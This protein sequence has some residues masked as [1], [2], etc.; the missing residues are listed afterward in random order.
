M[1][2]VDN[3]GQWVSVDSRPVVGEKGTL[4]RI[5]SSFKS[6][7]KASTKGDSAPN[8]LLCL[9]IRCPTATYDVNVEPAKDDVLFTDEEILTKLCE[10]VFGA[11][12]HRSEPEN[13]QYC[14]DST[15]EFSNKLFTEVALRSESRSE[16]EQTPT[17]LISSSPFD[18]APCSL[19]QAHLSNPIAGARGMLPPAEAEGQY[20]SAADESQAGE[21]P[22]ECPPTHNGRGESPSAGTGYSEEIVDP[23]LPSPVPLNPWTIARMT[24]TSR[25]GQQPHRS[26]GELV[27]RSSPPHPTTQ[28]E[29]RVS[30]PN[31]VTMSSP[32]RGPSQRLDQRISHLPASIATSP[33]RKQGSGSRRQQL[34][35]PKQSMDNWVHRTSRST[36]MDAGA[37]IEPRTPPQ[38]IVSASQA[39]RRPARG[40]AL[41]SSHQPFKMPLTRQAASDA[42]LD[43]SAPFSL[44]D[45]RLEAVASDDGVRMG[46]EV[47]PNVA[48]ADVDHAHCSDLE[49][50]PRVSI[51][52]LVLQCNVDLSQIERMQESTRSQDSLVFEGETDGFA[53]PDCKL[54]ESS[55]KPMPIAGLLTGPLDLQ[56]ALRDHLAVFG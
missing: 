37:N 2:L 19:R 28:R 3:V 16:Q 12:Y 20:E 9:D 38:A 32:I 10:D 47:Q 53:Q 55:V 33:L 21:E 17:L 50:D 29:E 45:M 43:Q 49:P 25:P 42:T 51:S 5:L 27:T 6:H 48:P 14:Q 54:W 1:K 46:L 52:N 11:Y 23:D 34:K 40:M 7:F 36:D 39:S 18:A 41:S 13:R 22:T 8:P 26:V 44:P 56:S 35:H 30:L 31:L 24:A 4:K 15:Q